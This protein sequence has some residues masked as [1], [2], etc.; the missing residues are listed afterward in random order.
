MRR[1]DEMKNLW[2]WIVGL[3]CILCVVGVMPE[4]KQIVKAGNGSNIIPITREEGSGTRGAFIG[5][6]GLEKRNVLGELADSTADDIAVVA[7]SEEMIKQIE[8]TQNGV[9]YVSYALVKE[10][11]L[12][13]LVSVDG[14]ELTME[15][16]KN[17]SYP[18]TRLFNLVYNG[19]L[20][21]IEKDFL[22]YVKSKGQRTISDFCVPVRNEGIYL[23]NGAAG[24]LTIS[25]STSMT[26][27]LRAL[28]DDYMTVNKDAT[29]KI[30]SSD[31]ESGMM[32]VMAGSSNFGMV[33]RDLRSYENEILSNET[34]GKDGIAIIVNRKNELKDISIT[35]LEKI[36]DKSIV[37]WEYLSVSMN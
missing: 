1:M 30:V 32:D 26:P 8:L 25:G 34:I 9:G 19:K 2:K 36:Y 7:S 21:A 14:V 29:V 3:T 37:S 23:S 20:T 18:L 6:T 24:S 13:K 4:E 22:Q 27:M 15:H 17:G 12:V 35:Q 10:V 5:L 33:S 16:M 11:D 31:S 28:A